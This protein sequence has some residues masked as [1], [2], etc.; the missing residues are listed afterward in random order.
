MYYKFLFTW[1][2]LAMFWVGLAAGYVGAVTIDR[3][4]ICSE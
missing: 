1:L 2:M 4:A 3:E